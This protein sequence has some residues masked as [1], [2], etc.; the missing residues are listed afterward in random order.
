MRHKTI[1]MEYIDDFENFH[2]PENLNEMF[3]APLIDDGLENLNI[4]KNKIEVFEAVVGKELKDDEIL[5]E[6]VF[7]SKN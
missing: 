6:E 2:D 1:Q 3:F 5:D 4:D 7:Y